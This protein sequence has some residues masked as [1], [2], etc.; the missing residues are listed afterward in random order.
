[1]TLITYPEKEKISKNKII[2]NC[3]R[4]IRNAFR[5][6]YMEE[7]FKK[8]MYPREKEFLQWVK[9]YLNELERRR[10]GRRSKMV[11]IQRTIFKIKG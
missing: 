4:K 10:T 8:P 6:S 5:E 11:T 2:A 3:Y 9:K 1:M 7:N